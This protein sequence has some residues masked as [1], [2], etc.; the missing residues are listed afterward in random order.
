MDSVLILALPKSGTTI[1]YQMVKDSMPPGTIGLFEPENCRPARKV[2]EAGQGVCAKVL[3]AQVRGLDHYAPAQCEFYDKK[4]MIVR[5]PRDVIVSLFLYLLFHS[6]IMTDL[7]RYVLMVGAIMAKERQPDRIS[8]LDL[9]R[10]RDRLENNCFP[11]PLLYTLNEMNFMQQVRKMHGSGFFQVRYEDIIDRRLGSLEDYLGFP[12]SDTIE[13]DEKFKRVERTKGYGDW[14]NWFL[15]EDVDF[16]RPRLREYMQELGMPDDWDLPLHSG[17]K[18]EN[19]SGYVMSL[20]RRAG[21]LDSIHLDEGAFESVPD[22]SLKGDPGQR[23]QSIPGL[24][25]DGRS[26]S[27]AQ[28]AVISEPRLVTFEGE[29]TNL[30]QRGQRYA[31]VFRINMPEAVGPVHFRVTIRRRDLRLG[32]T[33]ETK[34]AEWGKGPADAGLVRD[35]SLPFICTLSPGVYLV[36]VMAA[37]TTGGSLKVRHHLERGAAFV[38]A[39]DIPEIT[40]FEPKVTVV[41]EEN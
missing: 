23:L 36:D 28:G 7:E 3:V 37:E 2:R 35:I 29:T 34:P 25:P 1:L 16:F 15:P 24:R 41:T 32:I 5:D 4:M 10:L 33:M 20:A 30:L 13:V 39:N 21:V 6:V 12:L 17:L 11:Q 26:E 19:G 40:F 14:K 31:C 27:L 18:A 9:V 22:S 38:V 8:F